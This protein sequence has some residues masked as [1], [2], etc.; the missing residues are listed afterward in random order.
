LGI[1]VLGGAAGVILGGI[2]AQR[3]WGRFWAWDMKETGGLSVI[4]CALVLYLLVTRLKLSS[5]R[6]GQASVIMSLVIFTAW[7]GPVVYLDGLGQAALV[8]LFFGLIVQLSVL[9]I[10]FLVP[11]R[12]VRIQGGE[13]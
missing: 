5:I 11:P 7:F 4:V 9:C 13:Y 1:I 3:E 8:S 2:W 6:L 12:E 10:S